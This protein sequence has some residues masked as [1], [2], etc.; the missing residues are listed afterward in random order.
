MLCA[1][2]F[3]PISKREMGNSYIKSL[4]E[5]RRF[6]GRFEYIKEGRM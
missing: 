4:K 1:S 3:V 6:N 5:R 2:L